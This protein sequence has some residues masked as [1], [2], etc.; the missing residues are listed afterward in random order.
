M[1]S[2]LFKFH[3]RSLVRLGYIEKSLEGTYRLT[4]IGKE[5]AN[6][7][8]KSKRAIQKQPKLSVLIIVSRITDNK[9][10]YLIQ[11][12]SRNPY[13]DYY[14]VLSGPIRWGDDPEDVAQHELH[15]QTGLQASF[16][17]RGHYR[18]KDYAQ[19]DNTLLEDKLF[20]VVEAV[21]VSGE[22]TNSWPGG[23]NYWMTVSQLQAEPKYFESS[24]NAI[25]MLEASESYI[26]VKTVFSAKNY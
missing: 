22:I 6:N 26:S 20:T 1:E 4:P 12:R 18:Q 10:E 11:K 2:D 9:T 16:T 3:L 14:G 15:K 17:V 8:D 25:Q 23:T 5:L 7:L 19:A 21:N 24:C 13:F